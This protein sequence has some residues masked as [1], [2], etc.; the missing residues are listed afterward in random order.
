MVYNFEVKGIFK[1]VLGKK[2]I[3]HLIFI[4]KK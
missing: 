2:M 1:S 4:K 3:V